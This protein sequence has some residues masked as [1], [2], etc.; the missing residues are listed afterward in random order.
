MK[1]LFT[2][3]GIPHYLNAMLNKLHAKG[4]EITVITPQK[5]NATIGKGVKMV[6][7][8]TYKHLTTPEKK[9]F[10]GKTAY[11][12]LPEIVLQEKPDIIVMGWPYFLQVFFQPRLRKAMKECGSR[13][14]IREIPFQ[15]PPYGRIKEY[16]RENPMYDESMR[17]MSQG[18]AFYLRQWLTALVRKYCYARVAGTLNYSTAAYDIIP[19]YGVDKEHIHV[20]Y[21]STDTEVLLREKESVLASEPLLPKSERRLLHIGRLVKWKRVDLLIDAFSQIIKT[22]SDAELLIVGDGPELDNLKRQAQAMNIPIYE[23]GN[24]NNGEGGIRFIGAVYDPKALGAYM[25]ESTVY[26][27]AGM[28]GLSINDAMTYGLPVLCSVCDSTERDLVTD[29]KNGYFFREGDVDSLVE[30]IDQLFA[31][32]DRCREMGQES[33]KIIREKINIDTVSERYLKAFK[34]IMNS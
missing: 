17:L 30:K 28:G 8:G 26:V 13:L 5:G 14:V 22:Y 33:E 9:M 19:S 2:F 4:I 27:L 1:V 15:T 12:A 11:P 23:V 31:S 32:P 6:E 10:Y 18:T 24:D 3:G 20:T 21:N 7:G 16:F 34:E 25:N 29:G